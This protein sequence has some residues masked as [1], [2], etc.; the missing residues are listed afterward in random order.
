MQKRTP[1]MARF[2]SK[3]NLD[4]YRKLAS[5]MIGQAEQQELL[6]DLAQEM[7]AFKREALVAASRRAAETTQSRDR[8]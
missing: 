7:N 8:I 6:A 1:G 4:R 5:G 3:S 2:F